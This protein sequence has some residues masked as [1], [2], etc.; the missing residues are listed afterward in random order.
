MLT[1]HTSTQRTAEGMIMHISNKW[2]FW[3]L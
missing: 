3:S 1:D 2:N